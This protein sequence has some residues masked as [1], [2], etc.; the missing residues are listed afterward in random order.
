MTTAAQQATARTDP[1]EPVPVSGCGVCLAL[2][3]A[4]EIAREACDPCSVAV[5]NTELRNHPHRRSTA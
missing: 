5:Q 3:T 1:L 2:A 4:R